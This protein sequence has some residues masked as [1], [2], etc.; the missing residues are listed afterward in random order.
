MR[1]QGSVY[2]PLIGR[3]YGC[4]PKLSRSNPVC[5]SGGVHICGEARTASTASWATAPSV[6]SDGEPLGSRRTQRRGERGEKQYITAYLCPSVS[7]VVKSSPLAGRVACGEARTASTAS[8]ATA[9]SV[10]SDGEPLGSRRTQR[11][12]ERGENQ[13]IT[14][15]LCA[16]VSSAVKSSPLAGRVA[17]GEARTASTASWATAPSVTS[18]GEPL[19]SRRTQRRGGRRENQYITAYL[20]VSVSWV[21]KSSPLAGPVACAEV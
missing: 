17:C 21:V 2:S 16:S 10:T 1:G 5:K 4:R 12:G 7:S 14:A 9:P 19:G 18:D 8:W 11:R 6:T 13:Y 3:I 15:Y 20:C